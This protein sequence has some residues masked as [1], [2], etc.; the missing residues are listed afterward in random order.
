M[1]LHQSRLV[2]DNCGTPE[3]SEGIEKVPGHLRLM[4]RGERVT[5]FRTMGVCAE[6][7][8]VL[9]GECFAPGGRCSRCGSFMLASP[10]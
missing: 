5:S 7:Y 9:C 2:C 3:V 10:P 8:A 6:C 1:F 4:I